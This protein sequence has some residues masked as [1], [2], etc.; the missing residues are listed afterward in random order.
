ML[1]DRGALRAIDESAV[2]ADRD[3]IGRRFAELGKNFFD[4]GRRFTLVGK[5]S[6]AGNLLDENETGQSPSLHGEQNRAGA[7]AEDRAARRF[8]E[9]LDGRGGAKQPPLTVGV[10]EEPVG[11]FGASLPSGDRHHELREQRAAHAGSGMRAL[12]RVRPAVSHR[13]SRLWTL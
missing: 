6:A 5:V 9:G 1:V 7:F 3:E 4:G 8:S 12:L 11:F 2:R 13:R 10:A